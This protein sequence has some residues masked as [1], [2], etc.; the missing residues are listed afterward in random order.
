MA[1]GGLTAL[2][3][4]V[5]WVVLRDRLDTT[6][7]TADALQQVSRTSLLGVI[8]YEREARRK[9]LIT[10]G[11]SRSARAES[12]RSLR[13]NLQFIGVDR[14][15]KSLVVT[16][17]LPDEGKSS[18]SVNLAITMAEAGWRVILVDG[19]LRRPSVP[20]Y[21]GIEGGTGLTD[22]LIDKANLA[23]VVQTWGGPACRCCRAGGSRRTP[24]SCSARR[25]C[26]RCSPSS[27]RSTT[28]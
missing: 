20:G 15:P 22:V 5:G 9:P 3:A 27:P 7:K 11:S 16:S 12:F 4:A 8:G 18:T 1:L 19:D 24:A 21:L 28:W 23:D 14:Q 26:A 25:A 17:C 10:G 2:F 6:V 13:T